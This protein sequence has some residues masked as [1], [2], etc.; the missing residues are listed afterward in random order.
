MLATDV[1]THW[2]SLRLHLVWMLDTNYRPLKWIVIIEWVADVCFIFMKMKSLKRAGGEQEK[3]LIKYTCMLY[4]KYH[5]I[6]DSRRFHIECV[7]FPFGQEPDH[8]T[9]Y[10]HHDAI[11]ANCPVNPFLFQLLYLV[12]HQLRASFSTLCVP[13]NQRQKTKHEN[14]KFNDNLNWQLFYIRI[15]V[16]CVVCVCVC[17]LLVRVLLFWK[18]NGDC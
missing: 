5:Y 15:C 6:V 1:R 13:K 7:E 4:L 18:N 9:P 16:V 11:P 8:I 14:I 12:Q 10:P 3:T 2:I 17:V